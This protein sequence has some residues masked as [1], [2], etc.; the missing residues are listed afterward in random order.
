MA[1]GDSHWDPGL[2]R[3]VRVVQGHSLKNVQV[4][5]VIAPLPQQSRKAPV[6][7]RQ[8]PLTARE[9]PE[10][11]PVLPQC[12]GEHAV[13]ELRGDDVHLQAGQVHTEKDVVQ[14]GV[15]AAGLPALAKAANRLIS[16]PPHVQPPQMIRNY[17]YVTI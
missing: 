17:Y 15:N 10:S 1:V 2:L 8:V 6:V 12:L 14:K 4:D 11:D 7:L 16:L 3:Q 5:H 13:L 9:L